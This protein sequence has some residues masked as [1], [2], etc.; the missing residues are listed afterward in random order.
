MYIKIIQVEHF[1]LVESYSFFSC[2]TSHYICVTCC[3]GTD[4]HWKLFKNDESIDI[5]VYSILFIYWPVLL[6]YNSITSWHQTVAFSK[7]GRQ[8][9]RWLRVATCDKTK[10]TTARQKNC[11]EN[12][13]QILPL[14][15][16]FSVWINNYL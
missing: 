2:F 5:F 11:L 7:F 12:R 3:N 10:A 1:N 6:H 9:S 13:M 15:I 4:Y 8:R 16:R 14:F